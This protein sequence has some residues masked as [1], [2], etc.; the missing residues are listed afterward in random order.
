MIKSSHQ[1]A[2]AAMLLVAAIARANEPAP[3]RSDEFVGPFPSWRNV[4]A[5]YG[6]VGDGVADDTAAIQRGLDELTRHEKHCVLYIPAGVY[7]ITDTIKTTRTT[8]TECMGIA[9]IG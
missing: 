1:L 4:K 9:V 8:H 2:V 3:I 6:A 5:D 7:R